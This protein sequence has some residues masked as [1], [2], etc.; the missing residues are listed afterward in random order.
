MQ[1][2]LGV[3][4]PRVLVPVLNLELDSLFKSQFVNLKQ[5][6]RG[7][8]SDPDH[9]NLFAI[10]AQA[11]DKAYRDRFESDTRTVLWLKAREHEH[12]LRR[13]MYAMQLERWMRE[14]S[15]HALGVDQL[16][17]KAGSMLVLPY[18]LFQAHPGPVLAYVFG[19][20]G[21]EAMNLDEDMLRTEY[22]SA[23]ED[24]T[25]EVQSLVRTGQDVNEPDA[26]AFLERFYQ[27]Y[28]EKL[29]ELLGEDWQGIWNSNAT[30]W[31]A[32]WL[33]KLK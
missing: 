5:F 23:R 21:V 6:F 31:M 30:E 3:R 2:R 16:P 32:R 10:P 20:L 11:L 24:K 28:N 4:R 33:D 29:V 22:R 14:F 15:V 18:E 8:Y 7:N 13:G 9:D 12:G 19:F 26:R 27:P 1:V 17:A 25:L